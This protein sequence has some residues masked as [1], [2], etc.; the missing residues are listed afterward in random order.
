MIR[1]RSRRWGRAAAGT[2]A[3]RACTTCSRARARRTGRRCARPA[4]RWPRRSKM[5][6]EPRAEPAADASADAAN[7]SSM[8]KLAEARKGPGLR[9]RLRWLATRMLPNAVLVRHGLPA[10]RRVALTF[11]DGPGEM[12][13]AYLDVLERHGAR[14]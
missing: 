2:R 5:L 14:A 6:A 11:D 10:G 4:P 13:G 7:G 1:R 8:P 9:S 12:T 3:R